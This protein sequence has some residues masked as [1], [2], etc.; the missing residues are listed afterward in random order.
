MANESDCTAL[1]EWVSTSFN[2]PNILVNNAGVQRD[3]D[4]TVGRP[5]VV[6]GGETRPTRCEPARREARPKSGRRC[7]RSG[8]LRS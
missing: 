7:R 8:M 5:T 2:N 3:I 6:D 4:F 1:A